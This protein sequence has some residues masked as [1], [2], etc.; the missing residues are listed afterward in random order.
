MPTSIVTVV[1]IDGRHQ[2][3][4][5]DRILLHVVDVLVAEE[6][7]VEQNEF[8]G[9]GRPLL[10]T[11]ILDDDVAPALRQVDLHAALQQEFGRLRRRCG[12]SMTRFGAVD[13]TWAD[14]IVLDRCVDV[15]A[16]D[17]LR[18]LRSVVDAIQQRFNVAATSPLVVHDRLILILD[19][20]P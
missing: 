19:P 10:V 1:V 4:D 5:A 14:E 15:L 16:T 3:S 18:S 11:D 8:V 2:R 17:P 9:L 12:G 6:L 7:S 13:V 20:N